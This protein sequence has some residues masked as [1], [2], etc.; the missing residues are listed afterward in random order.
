MRRAKIH[1]YSPPSPFPLLATDPPPPLLA[2][3]FGPLSPLAGASRRGRAAT[4]TD[5]W[6]CKNN[7]RPCQ[8]ERL[9]CFK[10][11]LALGF[12]DRQ[13]TVSVS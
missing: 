7:A 6:R 5:A 9:P 2:R 12:A 11:I 4:A 8:P 13:G 10:L 1:V 3:L